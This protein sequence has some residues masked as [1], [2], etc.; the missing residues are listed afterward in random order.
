MTVED[1]HGNSLSLEAWGGFHVRRTPFGG[2]LHRLRQQEAVRIISAPFGRAEST[3]A[4]QTPEQTPEALPSAPA[5]LEAT[6][7]VQEAFDEATSR[8]TTDKRGQ[9]DFGF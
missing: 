5:V 4:L 9:G 2:E 3:T 1:R 7:E 6:P 8:F